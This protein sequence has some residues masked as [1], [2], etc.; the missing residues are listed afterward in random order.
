MEYILHIMVFV[1]IYGI[2]AVSLNLVAGTTGMLSIAHAAFY[3]VGAYTASLLM[4]SLHVP[5]AGAVAGATTSSLVV[6]AIVAVP[7]LRTKDD[8]FVIA[9]FA[10]QVVAVGVMTNWV[11]VTGGPVGLSGVPRPS[12]LGWHVSSQGD[13]LILI[14]G[15]S[16]AM[17]LIAH[18]MMSSPFG[19][20]LRGIREDETLCQALGKNVF[21]SKI[22]VFVTAAA[23]AGLAGS[24]Y[25][26]YISFIDPTSFTVMESIFILSIIIIG[27]ADSLWGSLLG[28]VVMVSLPE[29]LRWIGLPAAAAA[30]LRQMLYGTMLIAAMIWRPQGILG[31][32]AF[33]TEET[34]R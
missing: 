32:Y 19:R 22:S 7:A 6:A 9:T 14:G 8:Y 3:G 10:L 1:S 23:M 18:R 16:A 26:T 2:L 5:F 20:L 28:A 15:C 27:G 31:E 34:D 17:L 12:I 33:G 25:A 29:V 21:L 30:H 13:F 11:P 4:L 24:L